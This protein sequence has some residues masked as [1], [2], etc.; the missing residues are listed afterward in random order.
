MAW[1]Q[2]IVCIVPCLDQFVP[3]LGK[4]D[5]IAVVGQKLTQDTHSDRLSFWKVYL[6]SN[7]S[8]LKEISLGF[9]WKE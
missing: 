7:Q 3:A 1:L 9:L 8:I 4:N 5:G 6:R 2:V